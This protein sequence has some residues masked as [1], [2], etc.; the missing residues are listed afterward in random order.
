MA[1]TKN[2]ALCRIYSSLYLSAYKYAHSHPRFLRAARIFLFLIR[3]GPWRKYVIKVIQKIGGRK[4][5]HSYQSP[6]IPGLIVDAAVSDLNL[7]GVSFRVMLPAECVDQAFEFISSMK[8]LSV[9]DPHFHCHAIHRI[10]YDPHVVEVA[11]RY[12]GV[13]PDLYGTHAYWTF[14]KSEKSDRQLKEFDRKPFHFDVGDFKS[15]SVFIYLTDVDEDCGPHVAIEGT[16]NTKG[17]REIIKP[18]LSAEE[19]LSR[20]GERIKII[21]GKKGTLFFEDLCVFHK[22][23]PGRKPRLMLTITYLLRHRLVRV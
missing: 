20:Y 17:L 6:L 7:K 22:H 11:R 18:Y 14:P 16:H 10:V 8:R 23:A 9:T 15:V 21:T 2:S 4:P 5:L 1:R 13:E 19:A 12:L 3:L